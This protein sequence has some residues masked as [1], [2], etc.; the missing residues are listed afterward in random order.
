LTSKNIPQ[1]LAQFF[2]KVEEDLK[3]VPVE[4]EFISDKPV[5]LLLPNEI[6]IDNEDPDFSYTVTDKTS[7]L[8]KLIIKKEET[9]LKYSGFN[10]WRPPL[11]WTNTTNTG[12]YGLYVRSA[13]YLKSGTGDQTATWT[14]PIKEAGHY[15]VF[16]YIYP[17]GGRFRMGG[18][19]RSGEEEKGEYHY[20][21]TH[22]DGVTEQ[23]LQIETAEQ[24]WNS[25]GSFYF[26]PDRAKIM[27]TN[28]STRKTVIADAIKVVKN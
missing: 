18:H 25:L 15:D 1:T 10:N 24:G 2:S 23:T 20:F 19:G 6:V 13:Y 12:F 5:S 4:G 16:T 17:M 11:N 7:L 8:Y 9:G 27:L 26:S 22:D 3:A 14:L 28:K 21:I